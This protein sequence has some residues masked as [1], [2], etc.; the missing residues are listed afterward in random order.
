LF[1][2]GF[3]HIE[4]VNGIV[5]SMPGGNIVR[6]RL[7]S[8]RGPAVLDGALTC[9]LFSPHPERQSSQPV[10]QHTTSTASR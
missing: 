5:L 8:G 4:T 3:R 10:G 2:A 1:I 6:K 9:P 7:K